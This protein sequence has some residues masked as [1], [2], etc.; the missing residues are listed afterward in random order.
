[1]AYEI[2]VALLVMTA[3]VIVAT[4]VAYP[5]AR[6]NLRHGNKYLFV[7]LTSRTI[8]AISI[9]IPYFIF[10]FYLGLYGTVFGV[11]ILHFSITIPFMIWVLIGYLNTLPL[12]LDRSARVD[13]YGR[14]GVFR[15]V[16]VPM[17][18]PA[19]VTSIVLTFLFS[20]NEFLFAWIFTSG[21]TAQTLPPAFPSMLFMLAD[22][23]NMAAAVIISLIPPIVICAF[24]ERYITRLK[25]VGAVQIKSG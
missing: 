22:P 18:G 4:I 6:F 13:G 25:I 2:V 17:A 23:N 16:I 5:L 7:V 10:F 12:D 24:F 11:A 20:W 21:T 1:M 3:T 19:I 9:A 15:K 8:P 14:L